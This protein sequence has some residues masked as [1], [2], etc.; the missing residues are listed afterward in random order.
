MTIR[1]GGF[2]DG[3]FAAAS[4]RVPEKNGFLCEGTKRL[5]VIKNSVLLDRKPYELVKMR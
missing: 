2:F 5:S 1:E 3:S 4:C